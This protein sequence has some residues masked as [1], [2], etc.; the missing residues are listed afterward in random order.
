[1]YRRLVSVL[2][3]FVLLFTALAVIP[4]AAAA[5]TKSNSAAVKIK[6]AKTVRAG[7]TITLKANQSVSW[8]SSN[9]KVATVSKKGVVKGI[10]AGKVKITAT[11]KSG[12]K[13]TV[14]VTVKP[15]LVK[16]IKITAPT[17]TLDLYGTKTVT[18]KA[19]ASPA[20]ATQKFTW[21]S[22]DKTVATVSSSGK[23]KALKVGTATITATATDG[24]KV[25]KTVKI[26][27]TSSE[28][29]A[30][31]GYEKIG[32]SMPT[33]SLQRWY[34]DSS[35]LKSALT[36]AG[37]TVDLR[38]ADNDWSKQAAQIESMIDEGCQVLVIAPVDGSGLTSVI[39]RAKSMGI[40]VISYDRLLTGT[41]G[42]T[43]YVT[44][45]N[46]GVGKLQGQY[47][48]NKLNLD[49]A[50]GPFTLEIT[51]GDPSDVAN[52][53]KFYNG[54]MSVLR[55]YIDSGKLVVTSGQT[56]FLD[57]AT[58]GWAPDEAQSR[59]AGILSSFYSGGLD[60]DAWLCPNDSTAEGVV[61]ALS[62]GYTGNRWP[63]VTGQDCD[64]QNVKNIIAGK[65]AM[66]VFK[67]TSA[68]VN[69]VVK[70]VGQIH[71]GETIDTNGSI[72][73][74]AIVV[75]TC[76]CD[77]VVVDKSNYYSILIDSGLYTPDQLN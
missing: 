38:Y 77:A 8:K 29:P 46:T 48:K 15:K 6:G 53:Q 40:H 34:L 51:A 14:T 47:I 68:L 60:L 45:D 54:A 71:A 26:T 9:K 66:S 27:V 61:N 72:N 56:D 30:E 70:I 1:M 21:K 59:A 57:V 3:V 36:N 76:L 7:E 52:A 12:A 75:P 63:I 33:E 43:C 50:P 16:S 49:S 62:N 31:E 55:P 42:V 73:N 37:Y 39:A 65:Q 58:P 28:Q 22:S 44:F 64:L 4:A 23:V 24:S 10:K 17:T 2:L 67:N 69:K 74:G 20:D 5:E 19:K 18:L 41:D 35:R 11:A 25:K 13:A 32:L